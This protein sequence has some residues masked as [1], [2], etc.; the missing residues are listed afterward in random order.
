MLLDMAKKWKQI[1]IDQYIGEIIMEIFGMT[2]DE[3]NALVKQYPK[4]EK[5][6]ELKA[7][8]DQHNPSLTL[9]NY[10]LELTNDIKATLPA[11]PPTPP[12]A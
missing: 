2:K 9:A 12:A 8:L 10:L 5:V 4:V 6:A 3:V 7:H 11:P 1:N